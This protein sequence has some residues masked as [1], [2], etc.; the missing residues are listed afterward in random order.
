SWCPSSE[1]R[2]DIGQQLRGAGG[3]GGSG[4][5]DFGVGQRGL[6][7]A[8]GEVRHQRDAHE[9][10]TGLTCSDG[11]EC[12]GHADE[13]G[14][15]DPGHAHLG[16]GFV[17]GAAEL[18]VD[19]LVEARIDVH[20]DGAH[21]RGVQIGEIDEVRALDGGGAGEVDV[22]GDED[23]GAGRPVPVESAA[24]VGEHEGRAAG[25]GRGAHTVGDGA[26]SFALVV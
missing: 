12:G 5:D 2:D 14:A 15:E 7:D 19:A 23:R 1:L 6:L 3:G 18:G 25:R 22:V 9:F 20:G 11:L 17:V 13:V 8:G 21:A 26:H 4:L 10:E 24:A 16:G